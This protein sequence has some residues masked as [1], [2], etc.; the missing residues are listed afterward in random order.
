MLDP[1]RPLP[2]RV[3]PH[4]PTRAPFLQAPTRTLALIRHRRHR[5]RRVNDSVPRVPPMRLPCTRMRPGT[6][7]KRGP[8]V[9]TW[10]QRGRVGHRTMRA[11]GC[12]SASM[13]RRMRP[14]RAHMRTARHLGTGRSL[15]HRA[16][17]HWDVLV[18]LASA[19]IDSGLAWPPRVARMQAPLFIPFDPISP[20]PPHI[21]LAPGFSTGAHILYQSAHIIRHFPSLAHRLPSDFHIPRTFMCMCMCI[22][23]YDIQ[24]HLGVSIV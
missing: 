3:L 19:S 21:P 10:P 22:C 15:A 6:R 13:T 14:G 8:P 24:F 20:P 1:T 11:R 23:V 5:S 7:V 18:W 9:R 16:L 4:P 12:A 17:G 2:P